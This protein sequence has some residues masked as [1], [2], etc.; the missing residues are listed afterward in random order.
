MKK[1][2]LAVAALALTFQL[3]NAQTEKGRQNIGL[4]FTV[5]TSNQK[6]D[7]A[8]PPTGVS[9]VQTNKYTDI[10]VGPNYS[11]FIANNLD[12]GVGLGYGYTNQNNNAGS[13]TNKTINEGYSAS[14]YLRKYVLYNNKFGFRTGGRVGYSHSDSKYTYNT[15]IPTG[16]NQTKNNGYNAGLMFDLV[17][18]PSSKLGITATLANAGYYHNKSTSDTNDHS[19][20]DNF[21]FN[22][23]NNG[24]GLSVFYTF[25]GK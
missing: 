25:G 15:T 17:Y 4:N 8:V 6:S 1:Q 9:Q 7:F 12:L 2:F 23:I 11:Y 5:T 20:S 24:L 18:Y 21:N 19:T 22:F 16:T 10:N 13:V 14:L 3:A